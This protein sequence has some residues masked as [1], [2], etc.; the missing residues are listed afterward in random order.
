MVFNKVFEFLAARSPLFLAHWI[1]DTPSLRYK[2]RLKG[3]AKPAR[4]LRDRTQCLESTDDRCVCLA[5]CPTRWVCKG[6]ACKAPT[7]M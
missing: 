3:M 4:I 7:L 2:F 5:T 6:F 1:S